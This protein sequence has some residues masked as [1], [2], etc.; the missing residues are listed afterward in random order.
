MSEQVFTN[1][2]SGGPVHVYVKDG[3]IV[4]IR[5]LVFKDTD[6]PSWTIDARGKRFSPYRKACLPPYVFS[7][8]PRVY[9]EKRLR[10]PM[11]RVDFDPNGKRHPEN[12]GRSGYERITWEKALDIVAGEMKRVREKYGPEAIASRAGSHHNFGN[13]GYRTGTWAR[14]FSMLGFT[15]INDNPDSWEGWHWG[16]THT[17]GYYWRLGMPEPYDML[18]DA[19][20]HTEMVVHWGN[21][22]DSTHGCY[23][24]Q[25]TAIWRLWLRELGIK[26]IV[27]DPFRNYTAVLADKWL[28]PRPGT[29]AALAMAIAY[30][31]IKEN[32]Y[33]KEYIKTH[34]VGFDEFKK[35]ILGEEDGTPRTPGWAAEV[36]DIPA[37]VITALAREWAS[38]P[39]MLA[40][41]SRG[42]ESSACRAAYATEYTR[43]MVL[44]LGM[45]GLGKP[46]VNL[47]GTT[48]GPPFNSTFQFPGY[49]G[50]GPVALNKVAKKQAVNSVKQRLYRLTVPDAILNP[51]LNWIGEGFCGQSLEQQFTPMTYPLPGCSEVKLL[52]RYGGS[53]ISTMTNTNRWVRMYQSP[54]LEFVATQDCWWS[55]ET[56]FADVILPACTTLERNDISEWGNS[57]GY[58]HHGQCSNNHR[59]IVY[60]KKCI[61]PVGESKSDYDI[62]VELADRLGFKDDFT[63]GGKTIEDWIEKVFHASDL[64]KIISFE[65]FKKR[66]Y[67]LIPVPKDYKPTPALRWFYEG[68][69]CDTPDANPKK[70]TPKAKELGTYS[71]KL[72]FASES[73]KAHLPHDEERPV[74]PRY[75]PSWE[76][77]ES[78][79]A[80]K[81]PLQLITPHP[82]FTFHTHHDGKTAWLNDIPD[83]RIVKNGYAYHVTRIHPADAKPRGIS[84]GDIVRMYNDR[85]SVLGIAQITER[86][87]PGVI[88]SYESSAVYDPLEPGKPGSTDRGGCVNL[89]TPSRMI[90]RNVPGMAPNSCLI[91]IE[92]LEE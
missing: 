73:L 51:P 63:D 26:Q 25:D 18:E 66:G 64:P 50:W 14:F 1:C 69:E 13:I 84:N 39:T 48:M 44:L 20:K 32:T 74:V 59:V 33:D 75:I 65:D 57:G 86:I 34:S 16:A 2:T 70:G 72:E 23:G 22:P 36:C 45:Q 54:K 79:L 43:L 41:G 15:D 82:R 80:K 89:L 7:E 28:A 58:G 62:F 87:R 37:R 56:G 5:P 92:K 85:G 31:W 38:K 47:W 91:E 10:Y 61:E 30:V 17:Y 12:R 11:K 71:G 27:I 21:D 77:H 76:G 24:G 88:H 29:D 53:F 3:R 83:H 90:A 42:G 6:A 78:E 35:L 55:P 49:A 81:Y 8:R 67:I 19:L 4:R 52:Y 9:S 60:Q 46:G 68:R 40:G